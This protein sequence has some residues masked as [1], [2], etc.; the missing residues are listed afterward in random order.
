VVEGCEKNMGIV[1]DLKRDYG[2]TSPVEKHQNRQQVR[3]VIRYVR[4]PVP[5]YVYAQPKRYARL[6]RRTQHKAVSFGTMLR[7]AKHKKAYKQF[8]REE[9]AETIRN[10][11]AG[12]GSVASGA[13]SVG[14]FVKQ[15]TSAVKRVGFGGLFGKKS[16]Y[17]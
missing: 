5:V 17:D 1:D 14:G 13:K 7:E 4:Q 11:R 8:K 12:F 10:I 16:I 9:R 2:M 6:G 15:R 3:T